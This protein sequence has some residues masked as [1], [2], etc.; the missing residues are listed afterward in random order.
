MST[1]QNVPISRDLCRGP[2]AGTPTLLKDFI[3]P[4]GYDI[5]NSEFHILSM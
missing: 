5:K 3:C 2:T 1:F 4:D